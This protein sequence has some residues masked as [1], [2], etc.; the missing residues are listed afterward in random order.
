MIFLKTLKLTVVDYWWRNY[1]K[2]DKRTKRINPIPLKW[3]ISIHK[4]LRKRKY[5]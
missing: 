5:G 2:L 4:I 3:F 1:S